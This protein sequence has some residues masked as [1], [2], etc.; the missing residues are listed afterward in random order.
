MTLGLLVHDQWALWPP[1]PAILATLSIETVSE[2][3]RM[4]EHGM[5]QLQLVKVRTNST[6]SYV[7]SILVTLTVSC[8]A[9]PSITNG[10]PGQPTST[11]IGGEVTYTCHTGHLLI[12]SE[13]IT[14]L[15]TGNWSSSP[16]CQSKF[17]IIPYNYIAR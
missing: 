11:M 12:G 6:C 1:T 9:P 16:S 13:T 14:C 8:G 7:V 4:T 10:Y 5:G 2:C 17:I 15:S 3:V